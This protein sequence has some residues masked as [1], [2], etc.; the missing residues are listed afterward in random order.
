MK[1]HFAAMAAVVLISG[2]LG[3]GTLT[4]IPITM[5]DGSQATIVAHDQQAPEWLLARDRM[6]LNFIVRGDLSAEQLQAV[7][8]T[9]AVCRIYTKTARPNDLVLVLSSGVLYSIAGFVGVGAGSQALPGAPAFLSY[10]GYGAAATGV[11]GLAN[12]V[13]TLGG[14]TYTFENCGREMLEVIFPQYKIHVLQ[15]SPY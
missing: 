5:P 11:A 3:P 8:R 10:G 6:K 13:I 1:A 12:G 15:K 2:C 14:K 4:R 9:E 7:A